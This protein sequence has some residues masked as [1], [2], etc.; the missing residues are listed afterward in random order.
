MKGIYSYTDLKTNEVVYIGKDS[1][2][3]ENRRHKNHLIPS[4][5]NKQMINRVLQNNPHRY[6]YDVLCS[7]DDCGDELLNDLE[8]GYIETYDPKFNF[9][10]GGEGT[11]GYKLSNETKEKISKANTGRKLSEEARR[12]I[13]ESQRG[14]KNHNYGV[15]GKNH[16]LYGV[17][18]SEEHKRK[19][20]EANKGRTLPEE[21]R[22]KIS[23]AN[24]GKIPWSKGKSFSDEHRKKMSDNHAD[25]NGENNPRW[26]PYA[27]V[28]KRGKIKGEQK[29]GLKF[30]GKMLKYSMDKFELMNW[31]LTNY[32]LEI[33]KGGC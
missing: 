15:K 18:K 1:H 19:L 9:T 3:E 17:P 8:M 14:E 7:S 29:Y 6:Q 32:P 28:I 16:Y 25:F 2:I 24:K 10:K 5:Y 22:K 20:S 21:S 26:K 31:F 27:R 30:N 13:S 4:C 23:E 12:K 11:L 33:I